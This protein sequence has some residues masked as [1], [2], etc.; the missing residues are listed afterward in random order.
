[1][2]VVFWED[3]DV[4]NYTSFEE[5]LEYHD[6]LEGIQYAWLADHTTL[7]SPRLVE[8]AELERWLKES[9]CESEEE[10]THNA[11]LTVGDEKL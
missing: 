4:T 8:L 2:L 3:K 7:Y 11:T 5:Y 1:M 10:V 9:K 6:D